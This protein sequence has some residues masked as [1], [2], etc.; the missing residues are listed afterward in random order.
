MADFHKKY[1]RC[2]KKFTDELNRE[3]IARL[4]SHDHP[5][6]NFRVLPQERIYAS[7]VFKPYQEGI[8]RKFIDYANIRLAQ[9]HIQARIEESQESEGYRLTIK[10]YENLH[11]DHSA[12]TPEERE[13]E[14]VMCSLATILE[15][16]QMQ[17][18][19]K[20]AA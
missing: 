6:L 11:K 18:K 12:E 16:F 19:P 4:V 15:G 2:F 17:T 13:T 14:R 5:R 10:P 20:R 8:L 3:R 7:A 9:H 1:L